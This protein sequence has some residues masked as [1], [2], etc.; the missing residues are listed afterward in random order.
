ME[1]YTIFV[2]FRSMKLVVLLADISWD[3]VE[4]LSDL[5][6]Q[7]LEYCPQIQQKIRLFTM[8]MWCK[9]QRF[10]IYSYNRRNY[11]YTYNIWINFNF[12][13]L[14]QGGGYVIVL[15][16]CLSFCEQD[17]WKSDEPIS[18]KLSVMI[19]PFGQ[20]NPLKSSLTSSCCFVKCLKQ[21]T[22]WGFCRASQNRD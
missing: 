11:I 20:S 3:C 8:E 9:F 12:Y 15:S 19:G 10:I 22:S 17:Y 16:V 2:I 18:L 14:K 7:V 1:F 21:R 5:F 6:I 13:L 4:T